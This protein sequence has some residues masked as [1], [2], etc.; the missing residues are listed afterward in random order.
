M[1]TRPPPSHWHLLS[2]TLLLFPFSSTGIEMATISAT[3]LTS[4][5]ACA[6]VPRRLTCTSSSPVLGKLYV[7]INQ[8]MAI[9][10]KLLTVLFWI[11]A[12]DQ[13]CL[14]LELKVDEG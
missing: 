11:W 14:G 3:T 13:D 10:A 8:M 2:S 5:V 9:L 6:A 12:V 4:T 7:I 1:P